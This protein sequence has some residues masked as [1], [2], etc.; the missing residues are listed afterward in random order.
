MKVKSIILSGLLACSPPLTSV[1]FA[2][3][4][5]AAMENKVK[6]EIL[7]KEE[8]SKGIVHTQKQVKNFHDTDRAEHINVLE[9]DLDDPSI[10]V[11]TSKAIDSVVAKEELVRQANRETIRG[12]DVVAGVNGDMF[13][14]TTGVNMGLQVKNGTLLINHNSITDVEKFPV[15]GMDKQGEAF[16]DT[17]SMKGALKL[18]KSTEVISALNRNEN[19]GGKL[20]IYTRG[21]NQQHELLFNDPTG[22]FTNNGALAVIS[23]IDASSGLKAGKRYKGKIEKVYTSTEKIKIPENSVILA[24]FGQKADWLRTAGEEG[25]SVSFTFDLYKGKEE[26][27]V[28]DVKEAVSSYNWLIKDG[29]PLTEQEMLNMGYDKALVSSL[30]ART[31]IGIKQDGDVVAVSVDKDGP[32]FSDSKGVTLPEMANLLQEAGAVQ[33]IGLDGGGSTEMVARAKGKSEVKTVNH[34]SDGKSRQVTNGILFVNKATASTKV[35]EVIVDKKITMFKGSSYPFNLRT[36]DKNGNPLDPSNRPVVWESSIG[37]VSKTGT[38]IATETGV[39]SVS[40]IVDGVRGSADVH[41]VD[42]LDSLTFNDTDP[43][44]LQQGEA[45]QFS[46]KGMKD[47]DPVVI[48][49]NSIKWSMDEQIGTFDKDGILHTNQNVENGKTAKITAEIGGVK[50][51]INVLI[52]LKESLLDDFEHADINKYSTN[53]SYVNSYDISISDEQ[54]KSGNYSL[55][56]S[57][58]YSGWK[59]GNGAMYITSKEKPSTNNMPRSIGM[60]VYGDNKAPWLRAQVTDGTGANK[61]VSFTGEGGVDW[62]GWKYVQAPI[63]PSWKL[64]LSLNQI[65]AVEIDKTHQGDALYGGELFI[66]NVRFVYTDNEDLAGPTFANIKPADDTVY[67][68]EF[69]VSADVTDDISGVDAN[70]ITLSVDGQKIHHTYDEASG[71]ISASLNEVAE[72]MHVISMAA[73]DKAGNVAIPKVER[74]FTVDLSEDTEKP[75]LSEVTPTETAIEKTNTPR[76]AFKLVDK[77]SGIDAKDIE[78]KVDEKALDVEYDENTGWGYALVSAAIPNGIH[79]FTIRAK[80]RSENKLDTLKRSFT[81]D[82]IRQPKNKNQYN[83][84]I[85]PDTHTSE[86]GRQAF[87]QAMKDDTGLVIHMGDMVDQSNEQEWMQVKKDVELVKEKP[88]VALAGNHEAFQGNLDSYQALF[89]SSTYH[90]EYGNALIV[91]LNTAYGQGLNASDSMQLDYLQE[92]LKR[93]K[94]QQVL[95]F[96]HVPTKDDFGTAHEMNTQDTRNF[97]KV[98]ETYKK[99]NPDTNLNVFFGHLHLLQQWEKNGVTYT[100]TGNAAQK[101]YVSNENGNILGT[102]ILHINENESTYKYA[103]F[104]TELHPVDEA[105]N[106]NGVLKIAEGATRQLHVVGDFREISSNYLLNLTKFDLL[107]MN[108]SSSQSKVVKVDEKGIITAEKKGKSTITIKTGDKVVTLPIEVVP[109][110]KINPVKIEA[111]PTDENIVVG[112][113]TDLQVTAT[114]MYNNQFALSPTLVKWSTKEKEITIS[115]QGRLKASKSGIYHISYQYKGRAGELIVNVKEK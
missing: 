112:K 43:V 70:S 14:V 39:G 19:V 102:G 51:S 73:T 17:L 109:A 82:A 87:E 25:K 104:L 84:S 3:P 10:E 80:D 95:V 110:S 72:G 21:M 4:A 71:R 62:T 31:A 90:F 97:E 46:F 5:H 41:V 74:T 42:Q 115:K 37:E 38:L 64:P 54:V 85:I 86:Y 22:A 32:T 113:S 40:A 52:G 20:A 83:I 49:T 76:I 26:Q 47:G 96:T 107:Q 27:K 29:K 33:A 65:Y 99:E 81:I 13:S 58:D 105:I 108:W 44:V 60:W 23:G 114:D 2:A 12:N 94:K 7:I 56:L 9:A 50:Q 28:N 57:Y 92:V 1:F 36:T 30:N 101:G 79:N 106:R 11:M 34:P 88:F 91:V 67:D 63:D 111:N 69:T 66:D 55:K 15:F 89:G 53:K 8:I 59:T 78:V 103:P 6:E 48:D 75:V 45:K 24:G 100:I 35:G 18:G 68:N 93:N 98:L 16:I 61:T 77:K